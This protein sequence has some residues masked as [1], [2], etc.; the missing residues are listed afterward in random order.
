MV[1]ITDASSSAPWRPALLSL[2]DIEVKP[3]RSAKRKLPLTKS[4]LRRFL[5]GN[6]CL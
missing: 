6:A 2:S 5:R 1:L 3:E 4:S